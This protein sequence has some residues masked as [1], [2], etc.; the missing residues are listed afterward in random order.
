MDFYSPITGSRLSEPDGPDTIGIDELRDRLDQ[1]QDAYQRAR[2]SHADDRVRW[3]MSFDK[4][5]DENSAL[6]ADLAAAR[7]QNRAMLDVV[8][9]AGER[10]QRAEKQVNTLLAAIDDLFDVINDHP[11]DMPDSLE[12]AL[13]ALA[14]IMQDIEEGV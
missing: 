2:L 10:Q 13:I 3:G 12:P 11:R 7:E 5:Q 6:R 8:Q 9:T 1:V 4:L 14:A